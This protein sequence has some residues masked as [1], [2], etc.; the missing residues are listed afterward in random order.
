MSRAESRDD[1]IEAFLT[2]FFADVI[3]EEFEEIVNLC[4]Y[5]HHTDHVN[6]LATLL[7]SCISSMLHSQKQMKQI[8]A[9]FLEIVRSSWESQTIRQYR[10]GRFMN[11]ATVGAIC[12][13]SCQ[14]CTLRSSSMIDDAQDRWFSRPPLRVQALRSSKAKRRLSM[15]RM[16]LGSHDSKS[17]R[18][19]LTN[20][21]LMYTNNVVD[22]TFCEN[23]MHYEQDYVNAAEESNVT[24]LTSCMP[25]LCAA[26]IKRIK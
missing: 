1:V 26:Y 4:E 19:P 11:T 8:E 17:R 5:L 18:A 13:E 6:R 10:D 23:C 16:L 14:L 25:M 21:S 3:C 24:N 2:L 12:R 7:A 20:E 15:P 22:L 9:K